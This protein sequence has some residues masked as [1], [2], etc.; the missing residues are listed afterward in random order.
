MTK[1][2]VK[3]NRYSNYA[4]FITPSRKI[5]EYDTLDEA[6]RRFNNKL[7]S[8]KKHGK[9]GYG[10]ISITLSLVEFEGLDRSHPK[11]LKRYD[12]KII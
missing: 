11:E 9:D 3:T 2:I 1:Y 10:K 4:S 7:E 12:F 6:K 8:Y 5:E